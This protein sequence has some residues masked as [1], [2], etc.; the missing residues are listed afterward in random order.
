MCVLVKRMKDVLM[1]LG[2]K[3]GGDWDNKIDGK[4]AS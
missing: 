2:E 4:I 1:V 3:K